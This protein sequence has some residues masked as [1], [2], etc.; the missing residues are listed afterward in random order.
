MPH[1]IKDLLEKEPV[2]AVEQKEEQVICCLEGWW[3]DP[4]RKHLATV[5][6]KKTLLTGRNL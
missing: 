2:V 6:R 4:M 3:F 1:P 5:G